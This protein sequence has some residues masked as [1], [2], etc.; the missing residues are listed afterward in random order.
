MQQIESD[1]EKQAIKA[2]RKRSL[3][4]GDGSGQPRGGIINSGYNLKM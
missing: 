4:I 2:V 1:I 3:P